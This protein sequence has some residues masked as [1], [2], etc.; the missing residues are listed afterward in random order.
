MKKKFFRTLL[1]SLGVVFLPVM[2]DAR[3][4]NVSDSQEFADAWSDPDVTKIKLTADIDYNGPNLNVSKMYRKTDIE[5]T[6]EKEGKEWGYKLDL[7]SNAMNIR[8]PVTSSGKAEFY[9]HDII[10]ENKGTSGTGSNAGIVMDEALDGKQASQ[11]SFKLGNIRVPGGYKEYTPRYVFDENGEIVKYSERQREAFFDALSSQEKEKY[12]KGLTERLVRAS[13]AQMTVYGKMSVYTRSEN[14]YTGGMYFE[15]GT[16]YDGAVTNS[17]YSA[18]WFQAKSLPEDTGSGDFELGKGSR[19]RIRNTGSGSIYPAIFK[20]FENI[21]VNEDAELIATVPG[22]AVQFVGKNK[23]FVAKKNSKVV[24]NSMDGYPAIKTG[25]ATAGSESTG[26]KGN[27]TLIDFQPGSSLFIIG[28]ADGSPMIDLTDGTDNH[29]TLNQPKQFDIRNT[30]SLSSKKTSLA[31]NTSSNNTFNVLNSNIDMWKS[32]SDVKKSSDFTYNLVESTTIKSSGRNMVAESTN[33][34]LENEFNPTNGNVRRIT[35]LN[36]MPSI[37]WQY[38]ITDADKKLENVIRVKL[39]DVPDDQGLDNNGD[40]HYEPV[41]ASEDQATVK[42]ND[43]KNLFPKEL[44]TLSEGFVSLNNENYYPSGTVVTAQAYR[45]GLVSPKRNASPVIDITPPEITLLTNGDLTTATKEIKGTG[46]EKNINGYVKTSNSEISLPFVVDGSGNWKVTLNK[47]LLKDE[48]VS[49]YLEDKAGKAPEY[50]V[51]ESEMFGTGEMGEKPLDLKLPP[52]DI[53]LIPIAPITNN[54][55]GNINPESSL[56]YRDAVFKPAVKVKVKEIEPPTPRIDKLARALTKD[57]K[58]NQIPQG[59][60]SPI[61]SADWQGKITK[62]NNTLSYR[63]GVRIPGTKGEDLQKVLYN[64]HITDKIPDYLTFK[65]EDVKVWKYNKGDARG[66]PIRYTDNVIG[67]D[68]KHQFN[69]G[70]INL[71]ASE[72]T[73]IANPIVEYNESTKE[74]TVGI[75]DRSKNIDNKYIEYGYEGDNKYGHLLPGDNVVI[76]FP[77]VVTSDAVKNTIKN[78]GKITGYSAEEISADPLEYKKVSVTSNEALNPGGEVSGEL[79]LTSAPKDITFKNTNLSDYGDSVLPVKVSD[80]LIVKDTLKDA[81]WEVMVKLT[82]EVTNQDNNQELPNSLYVKYDKGKKPLTPLT[83]GDPVTVYKSDLDN[84]PSN[85]EEFNISD[86]WGLL[87]ETMT[88][89]EKEKEEAKN[90][91]RMQASKIPSKGRY[92]GDLEWTIENTQ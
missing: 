23:S 46:K 63:I 78:V 4:E 85:Q 73:P 64:A 30:T 41:Y 69:M 60:G 15:P 13:R 14:Y 65:K 18:I 24:L 7:N 9:I 90:G 92:Q 89:A 87:K 76:E 49:I 35:G 44:N 80:P 36:T 27:N 71:E 48:T 8:K 75:G 45:S 58:G 21:I 72:A 68:G 11:W 33:K 47:K 3:T 29:V 74:L 79:L 31:V 1:V 82:K 66:M 50:L 61:T 22:S 25:G 67:A 26:S 2:A 51:E 53:K 52:R 10:L 81:N 19:V 59:D 42:I 28:P 6:G 16:D 54:N 86:E 40:L 62:V 20:S 17:D 77:T 56:T 37:E 91:L 5:L 55:K 57:D 88:P 38:L 32:E 39:G 34:K 84:T 43:N 83:L 70:D 12:G